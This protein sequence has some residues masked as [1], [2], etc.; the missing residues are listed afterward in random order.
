MASSTTIKVATQ[1]GAAKDDTFSSTSTGLSEDM[2][3][4]KL[5]VL[6]NDP[7]AARLYSLEQDVT[8]TQM[9]VATTDLTA[10]GARVTINADGTV[11]YDASALRGDLQALGAGQ[12]VTDTFTY[13]VRMANGALSTA[14]VTVE[15]AGVNDRPTL[16]AVEARTIWDT[17][18]DDQPAPIT[19]T[20]SGSDIDNG[21]VVHYALAGGAATANPH[22][23]SLTNDYGTLTLDTQSGA[24]SF[25]VNAAALNALK[26]GDTMPLSFKVTAVDSHNAASDERSIDITLHGA[27]DAAEI[28]GTAGGAVAEDGTLTAA[29]TLTVA[30]RDAGESA[31]VAPDSAALTGQYGSFSFDKD[32]GEWTYT[33]DND[34]AEVQALAGGE[35]VS[36]KLTVSSIDGTTK[37][38]VVDISGSNDRPTLSA[39]DAVEL[40]D[41]AD[42]DQP[43]AVAG[44]LAGSD[45]DHGDVVR[46]A[47]VGGAAPDDEGIIVQSHAYGT[48]TFDTKSGEY[49][50]AVDA[51]RL[52]ALPDGESVDIRFDVVAIDTHDAS[53]D[54]QAIAITLTG[55]DDPS[56]ITGT[57]SGNVAED[58]EDEAAGT[59][60]GVDRDAG[61]AALLFDAETLQGSYGHFTFDASSG[62]WTYALDNDSDAVQQLGEDDEVSDTLDVTTVGGAKQQISVT[63]A[64]T[65]DR[66]T[67]EAPA[68]SFVFDHATDDA[69]DAQSG[70]LSGHDVDQRAVLS[71]AFASGG[72][73]V[74]GTDLV[75]QSS[76]YGTLTLNTKT[77]A[78]SFQMDAAKADVLKAGQQ[79]D[80]TFSVVAV[81]EHGATSDPQS[82]VFTLVGANDPAGI[83][84]TF[85]GTVREDTT[86]STGGQLFVTDRDVGE[87]GF[88]AVTSGLTGT[89]GSFSFNKDTGTWSY[90]L[91]NS[92]AGVQ[93]LNTADTRTDQLTVK[94]IDGTEGV[95]TVTIEGLNES[96]N[97]SVAFTV[98]RGNA[99]NK[100]LVI[101][102]F[103]SNDK[104]DLVNQIDYVS[105][106]LTDHIKTDTNPLDSTKVTVSDNGD[107][108]AV[109]LVGY[110]TFD[111]ATQLI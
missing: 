65:N 109:I 26:A 76:D 52:N 48:L 43:D 74:P 77:G 45:I 68:Q 78:Y 39:V 70:S 38:I 29:G 49:S 57:F 55:A 28:G 67:L 94:S 69:P 95:L 41:T 54:V 63:I 17:A 59:V 91:N 51:A 81:D 3:V 27:A 5:N 104:L 14:T 37:D 103:D 88:Q 105:W 87:A 35:P 107:I 84:G 44:T 90:A 25:V 19:D 34:A 50:F 58:G 99:I 86:L 16:G 46:Y 42:D 15:L 61:Q 6:A 108:G 10:K 83:T 64:G 96:T 12:T 80:S 24:Y 66:P 75:T 72:S 40:K 31:F 2:L 47:L 9:P 56:G 4:T 30:D 111:P 20:I 97:L 71:Y 106:S 89:Y 79:A 62:E 82:L 60:T 7:G 23:V 36:D 101:N 8:G 73:A 98:N 33:L 110:T 22:E 102:N 93:A 21:D 85:N 1:T 13:T 11:T 92:A 18:A 53:S 32:S 100:T